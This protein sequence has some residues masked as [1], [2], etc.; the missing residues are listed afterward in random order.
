MSKTK[1]MTPEGA[2]QDAKKN[3]ITFS[4]DSVLTETDLDKRFAKVRITTMID[5]LLKEKLKKEA[6]FSGTKYQVLLNDI[7]KQYFDRKDEAKIEER[8][9]KVENTLE[10]ILNKAS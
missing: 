3:G 2:I 8:L 4:K 6:E 10:K 5:L 7:L 9:K 1:S